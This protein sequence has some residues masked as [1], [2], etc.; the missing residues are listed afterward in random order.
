MEIECIVTKM[1]VNRKEGVMVVRKG[2]TLNLSETESKRLLKTGAFKS[3]G[4]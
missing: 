1:L 4:G 3:K 2:D